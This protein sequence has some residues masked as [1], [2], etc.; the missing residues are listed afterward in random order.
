MKK[1]VRAKRGNVKH[2]TACGDC[3]V[4]APTRGSNLA[5]VISKSLAALALSS[6]VASM[7]RSDASWR[8]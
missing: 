8:S 7:S 6:V 2:P 5:P 1:A 3:C 4:D